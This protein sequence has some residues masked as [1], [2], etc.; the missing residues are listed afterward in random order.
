MRIK[1][2]GRWRAWRA[3]KR[4]TLGESR[5]FMSQP[6][7]DPNVPIAQRQ[8]AAFRVTGPGPRSLTGRTA[9]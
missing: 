5:H 6:Y 1:S 2:L 8:R 4:I 9:L 7:D 3:F